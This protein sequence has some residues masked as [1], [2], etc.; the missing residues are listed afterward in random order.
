[1]ADEPDCGINAKKEHQHPEW[2]GDVLGVKK[3]NLPGAVLGAQEMDL[4]LR[5]DVLPRP[6]SIAL[7]RQFFHDSATFLIN[8]GGT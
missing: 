3:D 6:Q 8:H 4:P 5:L 1:M 7:L 2:D